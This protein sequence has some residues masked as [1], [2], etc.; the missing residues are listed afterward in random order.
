LAV[1]LSDLSRPEESSMRRR[2]LPLAFTALVLA[3]P[4]SAAARQAP[5]PQPPA[6]P[7]PAPAQPPTAPPRVV[8]GQD[9]I[10]IESGNGDFRLQI[11]VLA[12]ADGR[13]ALDDDN[14]QY[15]DTFAGR[16]VRPYFRGR[17]GRR[18]EFYL[19]PDFAGS[20]LVVQDAYIDTIFSP[21]LRV[22]LGK[23]K[24]PFGFERLHSASN[25]LFMERAFPTAIAPN[26]D[27]G[28]QVLGDL[29]G[30]VVSYLAG[31]MNGVA[32][33]ASADV[34]TN[35]GKDVSGRI[36]FRPFNRRDPASFAR[37]L[38]IGIA[39]SRGRGMGVTGLPVFR[40]QI[41]QQTYFSYVIGASPTVADGVRTRYSP[42][43]SY[44]RGPFGG[45]G[46]FVHSKGPVRRGDIGDDITHEAWQVA[47]SW[48]LTGENATDIG[49]GVRPRN[50]LDFGNGH[51]GAFQIAARYHALN[52]DE[53]AITLGLAAPGSSTK[54]EAWTL[55]LR[56]YLT[57]NLWYTLNFERT[58]FDGNADG[59]RHPEN[60]LAFRAQLLF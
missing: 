26:R 59:P 17:L 15:V 55:G 35:D 25:M 33:G 47:G 9:G 19:N 41:L 27:V 1:L 43:V 53:Q 38:A 24:T 12:H 56:W 42:S 16:R 11:G 58:V 5:P 45:W 3:S 14:Q 20:S 2:L 6:P 36:V 31:I 18:F 29:S 7:T 50:N 46:E 4:A 52:V 23:G 8:A 44:F 22:R 37:G 57:P 21:A 40:T 60:G 28:I 49:T 39:G 30:G 32:D 34:D 13:F 51:W 10:A 48:V 54:A